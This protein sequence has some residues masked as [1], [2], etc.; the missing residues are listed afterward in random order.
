MHM[1]QWAGTAG[2]WSL[3]PCLSG[4]CGTI[5]VPLG[6]V[7]TLPL[8]A[9]PVFFH[10]FIA[11]SDSSL[12]NMQGES[13]TQQFQTNDRSITICIN[14][15]LLTEHDT[16][17]AMVNKVPVGD[18]CSAIPSLCDY[19]KSHP[20]RSHAYYGPT[21]EP[22]PTPSD[23]SNIPPFFPPF[24]YLP[25]VYPSISRSSCQEFTRGEK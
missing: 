19:S 14:G 3:F 7:M 5:T 22:V 18:K 23:I 15:R 24:W 11:S 6:L 9:L 20:E 4:R 17:F 8:P 16:L 12:P 13:S 10:S 1:Q 21:Q 25:Q 2:V